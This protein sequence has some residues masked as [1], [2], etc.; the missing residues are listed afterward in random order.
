MHSA[1]SSECLEL[2][3]TVGLCAK[4]G[5]HGD[6]LST[7]RVRGTCTSH[8]RGLLSRLGGLAIVIPI[9]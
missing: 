5:G 4:Y 8:S 6:P 3:R 2:V 9:R 1:T 7:M